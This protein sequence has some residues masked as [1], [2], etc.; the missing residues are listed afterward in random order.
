L[1]L[2]FASN[3]KICKFNSNSLIIL[4]LVLLVGYYPTKD[5]NG[6]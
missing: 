1:I 2:I 6:L 4:S 3:I 5:D